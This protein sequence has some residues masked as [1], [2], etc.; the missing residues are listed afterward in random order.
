MN[1][2]AAAPALDPA[3]P[4]KPRWRYALGLLRNH[5]RET[6]L[7]FIAVYLPLSILTGFAWILLFLRFYPDVEYGGVQQLLDEAPTSLLFWIFA[8]SAAFT[9][10][11]VVGMSATLTSVGALM[12]GRPLTLSHALDPAFSRMGG[13]LAIG[14][15]W[16]AIVGA[17]T[18]LAITVIGAAIC[19]YV[20]LRFGMAF[21]LFLHEGLGAS[22]A[23]RSSWGLMRGRT[24]KLLLTWLTAIPLALVA[25]VA[26]V[27]V[28]TLFTLPFGALD[29]RTETIVLNGIAMVV[30]GGVIVPAGAYLCIVTTSFYFSARRNEQTSPS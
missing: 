28:V 9:L 3:T 26:V 14:I 27:F 8:I 22:R 11:L 19:L 4:G 13:L 1:P 16:Y 30:L 12:Q 20:L 29:G 6:M 15:V 21:H 10:F 7:P 5:P 2:D 18:A 24:L 23:L 17:G 25:F